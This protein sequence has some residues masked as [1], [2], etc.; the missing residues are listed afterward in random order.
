MLRCDR[1]SE[2][3]KVAYIQPFLRRH[4]TDPQSGSKS[5]QYGRSVSNQRIEQF[6]GTMRK[7]C[8]DWWICFFKML[9]EEGHYDETDQIQRGS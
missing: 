1:G 3:A 2:N 8:T 6:W 7:W 4:G 9:K 5:F